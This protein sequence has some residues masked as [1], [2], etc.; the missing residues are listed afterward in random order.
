MSRRSLVALTALIALVAAI[1]E[2]TPV[3]LL[4]LVCSVLSLSL[5]YRFRR[6]FLTFLAAWLLYFPLGGLLGDV[7]GAAW[8]FLSA[9]V[10]VIIMGERLSFDSDLAW[11]LEAP[12]G[13]DAEAERRATKLK[14]AHG[15]S[16]AL[17]VALC[18]AVVGVSVPAAGVISYAPILIAAVVLLM[19]ATYAYVRR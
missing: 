5:G 14:S 8:G 13:V 16:L 3:V 1:A 11:V 6:S 4:L 15:R 19:F 17:Y 7:L 9:A 2:P 18:A 12:E 10:V